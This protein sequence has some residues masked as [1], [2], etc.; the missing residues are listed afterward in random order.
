MLRVHCAS[1][2]R[3][4]RANL[5]LLA[6]YDVIDRTGSTYRIITP[7]EEYRAT[8][9]HEK[10]GEDQTCSSGDMIVDRQTDSAHFI[11]KPNAAYALRFSWAAT[12]SRPNHRQTR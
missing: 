8:A 3:R 7:S 12:S 10:F 5:G 4:R 6:E 11:A 2:G 9:M 1:A